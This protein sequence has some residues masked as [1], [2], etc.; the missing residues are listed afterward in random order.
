[1]KTRKSEKYLSS[2][3]PLPLFYYIHNKMRDY[4]EI[5]KYKT[6]KAKE[7]AN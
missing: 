7:A 1:L 6:L 3:Y 2:Q 4:R 5:R